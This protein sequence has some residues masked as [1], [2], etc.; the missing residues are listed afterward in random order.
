M[1]TRVLLVDDNLDTIGLLAKVLARR[2]C[3]SRITNDPI[4][5]LA[6]VREFQPQT[7]CLDIGMPLMDGYTLAQAIRDLPGLERCK[8]IAVSGYPPDEERLLKAGIDQHMLKPVSGAA[9]AQAACSPA[10]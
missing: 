1:P 6:I 2:D 8:I 3:E 9:L 10:A 4:H 7:V 5:A